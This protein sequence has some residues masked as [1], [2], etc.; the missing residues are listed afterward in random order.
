MPAA[1]EQNGQWIRA[2]AGCSNDVARMRA[3]C[4]QFRPA[5]VALHWPSLPFGD[6]DFAQ[7]VVGGRCVRAGVA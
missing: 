1:R 4:P 5:I 2:M 6:E 7:L 3:L